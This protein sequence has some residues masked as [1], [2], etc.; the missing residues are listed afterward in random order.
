[1]SKE[2]IVIYLDYNASVP[3]RPQAKE[4]LVQALELQGNPSSPH[5]LGRKLRSL[6]DEARTEILNVTQADR[7]VFTSGG[8]EANAL[9]L[10][11]L[12]SLPVL[13]S[14]IEHD[15]VLK[16][17]PNPALFPLQKKE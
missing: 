14:A 4:A 12:G 10:T 3:L 2:T 11:G 9:A 15:S 17:T 16:A 13:V 7:V 6:I 5:G 8:T 1:M